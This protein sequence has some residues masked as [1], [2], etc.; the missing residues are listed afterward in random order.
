MRYFPL[1]LLSFLATVSGCDMTGA[2]RTLDCLLPDMPDAW[3]DRDWSQ[4]YRLVWR[5]PDGSVRET[6]NRGETGI[7]SVVVHRYGNLPVVVYP[8]GGVLPAGGIIP[9]DLDGEGRLNLTWEHGWVALLLFRLSSVGPVSDA[10]NVRRLLDEVLLESGGDPWILDMDY[11]LRSLTYGRFNM[12]SLAYLPV[13]EPAIPAEP[14]EWHSDDPFLDP[15][16]VGDDG[17]LVPVLPGAGLHRFRSREGGCIDIHVTD[18]GW[19]WVNMVTGD[20]G[21]GTW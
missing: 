2:Y 18:K 19:T 10:L 5:G 6:L 4:G 8:E 3:C 11:A 17:L 16:R 21:F 20:A 7:V 12:Y 15:V 9:W 13:Y 1:C 14:G